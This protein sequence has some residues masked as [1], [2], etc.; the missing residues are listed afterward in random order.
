[1][2]TLLSILMLAIFGF[3][4]SQ[5][6]PRV[7]VFKPEDTKKT[8]WGSGEELNALKIGLAEMFL[9]D[10]SL[11]YERALSD[12]FTFE[13]GLGFTKRKDPSVGPFGFT[14]FE[15]DY[16]NPDITSKVGT[17]LSAG[18]RL[19]PDYVFEDFYISIE[20]KYRTYNW[21]NDYYASYGTV[22]ES[23]KVFYP[24][25]SS[26]Q[27]L[28]ISDKLIFDYFGGIGLATITTNRFDWNTESVQPNQ[29][30]TLWFHV[31][32]RFGLLF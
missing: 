27:S 1:M 29:T 18:F 9:G 30:R 17:A 31:G 16:V 21:D 8:K 14:F 26:G 24:R 4:F 2:K 19:Y 6:N 5:E 12:I 23:S 22:E 28:L 32:L 11:F 7:I 15:P 20:L 3:V 25:I 13:A 10:F